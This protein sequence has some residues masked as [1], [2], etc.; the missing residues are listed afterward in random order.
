[1]NA[2]P[3][4]PSGTY[5]VAI[6]D[7]LAGKRK[8]A[9]ES[10]AVGAMAAMMWKKAYEA[11]LSSTEDGTGDPLAEPEKKAIKDQQ[12]TWMG[13]Q[14]AEALS[15]SLSAQLNHVKENGKTQPST[16]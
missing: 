12:A 15:H 16:I 13:I 14:A 6:A 8:P 5:H 7:I 3:A 10:E 2:A 4:M 11:A 1:M 9:N